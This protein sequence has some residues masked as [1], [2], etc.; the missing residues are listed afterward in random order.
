MKNLFIDTNVLLDLLMERDGYQEAA[1]IMDMSGSTEFRLS[2]SVLSM[3]NIA[4]VLRKVL[5]S[6]ELYVALNKLSSF[7]HIVSVSS[8][9]Y[10]AAV[11]LRAR[12]FEDALQ[13]FCAKSSGCDCIITRNIKDFVFSDI[14]VVSPKNFLAENS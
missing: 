8:E 13:Y 2:V 1:I 3:S 11:K 14:P 4:Y 7:L 9:D 12:D 10:F 6:D 5:N